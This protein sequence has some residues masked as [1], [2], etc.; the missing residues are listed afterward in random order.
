[1]NPKNTIAKIFGA[2][3]VGQMRDHNEDNFLIIDSYGKGYSGKK[4]IGILLMVADGMGGANAGEVAS[5]IACEVIR[6]RFMKLKLIPATH[7][8]IEKYLK[9]LILEAHFQIVQYAAEHPECNGMGT[10]V[11]LCWIIDNLLH[12]AWCGDSRCYV[13]HPNQQSP[14]YPLTDDHSMVWQLVLNGELTA[15]EARVHENSNI[16][17][18]SVG[19]T[20]AKPLPSYLNKILAKGEKILV[21][22]DGLNGMLSD[23]EILEIIMKSNDVQEITNDLINA[24][25]QAGGTDNITAICAEMQMV[26]KKSG[27]PLNSYSKV[28]NIKWLGMVLLV[29]LVAAI[30]FVSLSYRTKRNSLVV[31][32]ETVLTD[33]SLESDTSH[34]YDL[35][36]AEKVKI[37]SPNKHGN[38]AVTTVMNSPPPIEYDFREELVK[39]NLGVEELI[40]SNKVIIQDCEKCSENHELEKINDLIAN[41]QKYIQEQLVLIQENK[42]GFQQN[43]ESLKKICEQAGIFYPPI[44]NN[45]QNDLAKMKFTAI[46]LHQV[47]EKIDQELKTLTNN[48]KEIKEEP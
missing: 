44:G 2:T 25:N 12:V 30:L 39:I 3:D 20:D 10:T 9:N 38:T 37:S 22:S 7:Q 6:D 27:T 45:N 43:E 15:E 23:A 29:A 36:K 41:T 19:S 35:H 33:E 28:F 46:T 1:M 34:V 48:L 24:A 13:Y 5:A 47:V 17:L 26:R 11:I 40:E 31:K 8:D 32:E 18:Q 14:L 16:I 42:Q 21:C 4:N